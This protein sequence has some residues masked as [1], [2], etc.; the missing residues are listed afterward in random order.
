MNNTATNTF[1][2]IS[3][4]QLARMGLGADNAT[5]HDPVYNAT[6]CSVMTER[7]LY[8]QDTADRSRSDFGAPPDWELSD[9]LQFRWASA[10]AEG[11]TSGTFISPCMANV[12]A[13]EVGPTFSLLSA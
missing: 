9:L 7:R 10:S 12:S 2:P 8:K 11:I 3:I 6:I 5:F 1:Q 4:D 13:A